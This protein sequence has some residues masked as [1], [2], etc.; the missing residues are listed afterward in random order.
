M[1]RHYTA[2]SPTTVAIPGI[3]THRKFIGRLAHLGVVTGLR[4]R[5]A[6]SLSCLARRCSR[7]PRSV[8]DTHRRKPA[9]SK[10]LRVGDTLRAVG[11][12]LG[13]RLSL[14]LANV[15]FSKYCRVPIVAGASRLLK[16]FAAH[17]RTDR[18]RSRSLFSVGSRLSRLTLT[19]LIRLAALTDVRGLTVFS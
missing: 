14:P 6:G 4:I 5:V 12:S 15:E 10:A 9:F 18:Y 1:D 2:S 19:R 11:R 7:S 16:R 17:P 8:P 13:V 3:A